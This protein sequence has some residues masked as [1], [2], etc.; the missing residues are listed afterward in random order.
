MSQNVLHA[1]A[2][3]YHSKYQCTRF[4]EGGN[5]LQYMHRIIFLQSKLTFTRDR[6]LRIGRLYPGVDIGEV[7]SGPHFQ[8]CRGAR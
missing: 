1:P 2:R 8:R 7:A 6:F 3:K 5:K 4:V